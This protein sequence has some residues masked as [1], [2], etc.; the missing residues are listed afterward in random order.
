M[1]KDGDQANTHQLRDTQAY[2]TGTL[3][4]APIAVTASTTNY[5]GCVLEWKGGRFAQT[6]SIY[7]GTEL[8]AKDLV[9]NTFT[10]YKAAA[11]RPE[12]VSGFLGQQ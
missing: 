6:F 7:R 4:R 8:I 1:K 2:R 3:P 5:E 12:C 10:D 11:Q 9:G